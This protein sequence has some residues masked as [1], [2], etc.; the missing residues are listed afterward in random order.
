MSN[1]KWV[2][3]ASTW[4]LEMGDQSVCQVYLCESTGQYFVRFGLASEDDPVHCLETGDIDEAKKRAL[5]RTIKYCSDYVSMF[6][7]IMSACSADML[8]SNE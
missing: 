7:E 5:V 3:F 4:H 6:S 8:I 2:K 1:L